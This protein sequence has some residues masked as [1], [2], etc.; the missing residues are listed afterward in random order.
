MERRAPTRRERKK[1]LPIPSRRFIR[2]NRYDTYA[3]EPPS[4]PGSGER[5]ESL[6]R[7]VELEGGGVA[8][9]RAVWGTPTRN[10]KR[11]EQT[12]RTRCGDQRGNETTVNQPLSLTPNSSAT[13][14]WTRA[15]AGVRGRRGR[16]PRVP[17]VSVTSVLNCPERRG[18]RPTGGAA[19]CELAVALRVLSYLDHDL[20]RSKQHQLTQWPTSPST[21]CTS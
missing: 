7:T 15:R 17:T 9:C 11:T 3:S 21:G 18:P 16:G 8:D 2:Y 20:D 14:A 6:E 5:L 10:R 19:F 4:E 13:R 1:L 12:G